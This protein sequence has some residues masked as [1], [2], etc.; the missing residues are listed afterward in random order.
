[1]CPDGNAGQACSTRDVIMDVI[2]D[3]TLGHNPSSLKFIP[4]IRTMTHLILPQSETFLG[5]QAMAI[6]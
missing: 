4:L 2:M 6:V 3:V 5:L 1:M